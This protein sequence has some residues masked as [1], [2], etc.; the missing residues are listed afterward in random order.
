MAFYT[1]CQ[2]QN[3]KV[4]KILMNS[5]VLFNYSQS[6]RGRM[7]NKSTNRRAAQSKQ[8][9]AKNTDSTGNNSA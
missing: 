4:R 6:F 1:F 5:T 2:Y 7:S 3:K 9:P 8:A